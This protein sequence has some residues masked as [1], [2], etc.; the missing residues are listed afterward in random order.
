MNTSPMPVEA[1]D[2]D[3]YQVSRFNAVRHGVLS[4]YTILPWENEAEYRALLEA[5]MAEHTPNGTYRGASVKRWLLA[6][7][8]WRQ[9]PAA[10]GRTCGVS[11]Q[12]P[13]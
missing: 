8:I 6:G 10:D 4:R 11:E 2:S 3:S 7:I 5:L 1:I 13:R 9:A 12:T